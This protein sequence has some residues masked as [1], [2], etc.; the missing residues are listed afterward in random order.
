MA[1]TKLFSSL[2]SGSKKSSSTYLQPS[3]TNTASTSASDFDD[4]HLKSCNKPIPSSPTRFQ[5]EIESPPIVFY[6]QPRDSSGAFFSGVITLDIKN[7]V[8]GKKNLEPIRSTSQLTK[9]QIDNDY[10]VLKYV[11]LFFIQTTRYGKPFLPN[12]ATLNTCKNCTKRIVELARWD[13]LS[14]KTAFARGS[15][16]SCPFSYVIPG[17][18]PA[19]TLLSTMNTTIEYE[20]IL[21]AVYLDPETKNEILVNLSH[22]IQISRSIR[23]EED[24]NSS[25]IFPPTDVTA[26][27]VIPNVAYPRST[28]PLE[29]RLDHVSTYKRRWKMRKLNWRF[30]ECVCVRAH[31]CT[32]HNAKYL[33]VYETTK[34][35]K[36][37]AKINK[38]SSSAGHP[39][40]NF[41]FEVPQRQLNNNNNSITGN[42]TPDL[43]PNDER[44]QTL[45]ENNDGSPP[46]NNLAPAATNWS[47][48]ASPVTSTDSVNAVTPNSVDQLL[49][50]YESMTFVEQ[51]DIHNSELSTPIPPTPKEPNP[52]YIEEIRALSSGELK[53]GWK[54]DF[55]G[56]GRIELVVEVSLMNLVS[57][58]VNNQIKMKNT[59][60]SETIAAQGPTEINNANCSIDIDDPHLGINVSHNLII[61][62]VVA[63]EMMQPT[64][65]SANYIHQNAR[66]KASQSAQSAAA[67]AAGN[68]ARMRTNQVALTSASPTA[69]REGDR[70][71]GLM[72][73]D[74]LDAKV[75]P[76]PATGNKSDQSN[77]MQGIPTGVARVLRMQFKVILSERSGVGISLDEEVPPTYHTVGS[78][79]PPTYEVANDSSIPSLQDL[80]IHLDGNSDTSAQN[81]N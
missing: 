7:N 71:I 48:T 66:L 72:E 12:S 35:Q 68:S 61:E 8:K 79:S 6:G 31:H 70:R 23:R 39:N 74:F 13:V 21:K 62:L 20:L 41:Y 19:T 44:Y 14:K 75:G 64:M 51:Q 47:Y 2:S 63:E 50:P 56:D 9:A 58:A 55:S 33:E 34:K 26:T 40:V 29:I 52:L 4:Y 3:T 59:V 37:S 17:C 67:I 25:R 42:A 11:T 78:L 30:E 80:V 18:V 15:T 54:S 38:N 5:I 49:S 77:H 69:P 81:S 43:H 10:V 22:P 53:S 36:K 46:T 60:D 73:D 65:A 32:E 24:R 16:H 76:E 57:M 27:A 45:Q 28:F 1:L